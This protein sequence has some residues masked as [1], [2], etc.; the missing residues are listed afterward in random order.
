MR[1]NRHFESAH[2]KADLPATRGERTGYER[3][4]PAGTSRVL[5][6]GG[7]ARQ[8]AVSDTGGQ[9]ADLAGPR[10]AEAQKPDVRAGA[11]SGGM[12]AAQWLRD[13]RVGFYRG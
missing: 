5:Q 12:A 9:R 7:E 11:S 10:P 6:R 8:G 3:H 2:S 13:M 1:D 4:Q